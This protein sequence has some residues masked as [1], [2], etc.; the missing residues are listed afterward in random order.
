MRKMPQLT[1]GAQSIQM[2]SAFTGYNHNDIIADGEMYD[3]Q[4]LSGNRYPVLTLRGKRGISSYDVEGEEP[5]PLTGIN[6]RDQLVFVRGTKVYYNFD[7]VTGLQVS[8]DEEMAPKKIVSFGAYECIWPDKVY[9]NTADLS[10]YG[11]M[12][13]SFST[14]G[15]NVSL[16]MCRGDG[17]NYDMTQIETGVNPPEDPDNGDL[18]LDESSEND[19]LRQ[20]SATTLEWVEVATTYVKISATGIGDGV[21]EYDVLDVSG[22]AAADGTTEKIAAQVTALNGSKTVY[23]AGENYIVVAGLI[24]QAQGELDS[25]TTVH[26]DRT[27][28]D[29]DFVC[30]SNN[31]LWGCKYGLVDNQVVNEI[32]ASK[33]GDFRNWR[34]Y[35]GISTDSYAAS[36]GTDGPFTGA[37][38][39][40]GYPVFFKED[41]I[42]R[43]SGTTPSSFTIQTTI[44][45]GVQNGNWRSL[46]V[47]SENIYYKARNAVMMYDG[48][49]PTA[50]SDKLGD[51]MY[52]DARAGVLGNKYYI[53]MRDK[54]NNWRLFNYDTKYGIWYKE[55][56]VQALGFAAVDDE[57]FY[58]DEQQN[59]LVSVNGSVGDAEDDFDWAA[60]FG[61]T[62]VNYAG[63]STYD[64]PAR[65]RNAKYLSMFKIRMYLEPG[66]YMRLWIKYDDNPLYE[67]MGERRGNDMRTFILPVIP[68]RC[69]HL[70]FKIT[71]KG[72]MKVFDLSRIMEVG[73]DG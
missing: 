54:N 28:P 60:E 50:V 6:G 62:G 17:T 73:G 38:T 12:E 5:V 43:V 18:W 19:V 35:L 49:M 21:K 56:S 33:L 57:L 48:N 27:L 8:D 44:A 2:T 39:Q 36:V 26:A 13:R 11:S 69:D 15:N 7:E 30:E 63:S 72:G 1:P 47:V 55:D 66:A 65:V 45:R 37:I 22:L 16:I 53:S 31:R 40:R 23:F 9:F 41:A 61:L 29:M 70:R 52:R 71:G 67:L 34:S 10:D 68:K 25:G 59:T 32:Y 20:Y 14:A 24:S 3:M 64:S 58:I 4:N 51:I 46:Q 42:H